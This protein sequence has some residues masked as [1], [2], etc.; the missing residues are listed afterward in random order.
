[1][2]DSLITSKTRLRLLVKFF[3]NAANRGHMRGLAE[4]FNEST[5]AIRKELNN[6]SEAGYLEKEADQNR[7]SY[8]ANVKHPLFGSLQD[9]VHKYLGLDRIVE[10]VLSR[11][12]DVEQVVLTGDY[13]QGRDSGTIE[14]TIVGQTLNADYL[15]QLAPKVEGVIARKV[16]FTLSQVKTAGGL[17]LYER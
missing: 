6:L 5:N 10:T 9:I 14:V 12:G 3:I 2:L 16:R 11:M 8:R 13:A 17:V 4:E 1:M 15:E 7:V